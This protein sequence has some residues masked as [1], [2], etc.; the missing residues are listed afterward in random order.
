MHE[1][2]LNFVLLIVAIIFLPLALAGLSLA[3]WLPMRKKDLERINKIADLKENQ[4]FYELGSGD[5]RVCFYMAKNNPNS[6]IIGVEIAWPLYLYSI[7][8]L[9][10]LKT[11]NLKLIHG[12]V[13]KIPLN[14]ADTIYFYGLT[15]TFNEKLL[16]KFKTELKDGS[17]IISYVFS[18]DNW[19]V[20]KGTDRPST[21]DLPINYY[22]K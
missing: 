17:K 2:L 9:K 16:P 21:K 15:K 13:F 10:L 12:N 7:V 11:Q 5:G 18:A 22:I 4:N 6:Q 19:N 1:Y 14:D 8:K 3:P 20:K